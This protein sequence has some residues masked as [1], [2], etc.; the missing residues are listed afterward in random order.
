MPTGHNHFG[1]V[2]NYLGIF[3]YRL[4]SLDLTACKLVIARDDRC[5]NYVVDGSTCLQ[6]SGGRDDIVC[7]VEADGH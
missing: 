6:R 7:R 3:S 4:S 2:A 1:G 5:G